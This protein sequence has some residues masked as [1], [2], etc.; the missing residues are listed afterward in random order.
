[1]KETSSQGMLYV[2]GE[3]GECPKEQRKS[4]RMISGTLMAF[5]TRPIRKF[6]DFQ[7]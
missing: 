1:M 3:K 5:V 2:E 4:S 7:R 6:E